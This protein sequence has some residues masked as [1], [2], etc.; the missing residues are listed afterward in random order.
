MAL[1]GAIEQDVLIFRNSNMKEVYSPSQGLVCK[2]R[3]LSY[4]LRQQTPKFCKWDSPPPMFVK[5]NIDAA[6]TNSTVGLGDL[7][8][9][10]SSKFIQGFSKSYRSKDPMCLHELQSCFKSIKF[11]LYWSPIRNI[12]EEVDSKVVYS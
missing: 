11:D 2:S 6:L 10:D 8:Q 5:L 9:N 1:K 7:L 4:S 3:D 12:I